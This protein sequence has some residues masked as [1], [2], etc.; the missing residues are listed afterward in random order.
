M[1]PC[2][3]NIFRS[4]VAGNMQGWE[5][6]YLFG[7]IETRVCTGHVVLGKKYFPDMDN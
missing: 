7:V 3:F 5:Y 4:R 1:R 2:K 6:A